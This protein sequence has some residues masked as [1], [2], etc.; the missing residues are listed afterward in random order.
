MAAAAAPT[1]PAPVQLHLYDL[2][3]GMASA[4]SPMLLGRHV[5]GIWHSGVVVHGR[6]WFFGYGISSTHAGGSPFGQPDMT[7]V[8][9]STEVPPEMVKDIVNDLRPRFRPQDYNLIQNNCNHFSSELA[10]LLTGEDIPAFVKDQAKEIL[11]GTA[12]GRQF[13]PLILSLEGITGQA[14]GMGFGG[15]AT[16]PP[17]VESAATAAAVAA[18]AGAAAASASSAGAAAAADAAAAG[19]RAAAAPA[20]AA[21][22]AA[23]ARAARLGLAVAERPGG[24]GDGGGAGSGG[25]SAGEG[26][27]RGVDGLSLV[28]GDGR[29]AEP[30]AA[31]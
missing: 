30:R 12:L 26:L 28:D 14:H 10:Q 21:A 4:L 11:E 31:N 25:G 1:G 7:I 15:A 20:A 18:A 2:T 8:L 13:A 23:E 5:A 16:A 27:A 24:G 19:G 29:G 3:R 9:G 22:A 17:E 6:E